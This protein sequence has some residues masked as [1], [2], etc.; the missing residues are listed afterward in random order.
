[1]KLLRDPGK[2]HHD[3]AA[4]KSSRGKFHNLVTKNISLNTQ[5]K[6]HLYQ[7]KYVIL[8]IE[9]SSETVNG[10]LSVLLGIVRNEYKT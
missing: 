6:I 4:Q 3:D 2:I 1:M 8:Q 10:R 7:E 9:I 5:N